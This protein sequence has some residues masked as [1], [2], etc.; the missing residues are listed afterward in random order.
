MMIKSWRVLSLLCASSCIS[1]ALTGCVLQEV[2][3]VGSECPPAIEH[4]RDYVLLGD[5]ECYIDWENSPSLDE[6]RQC[7]PQDAQCAFNLKQCKRYQKDFKALAD[8]SK[9]QKLTSIGVIVGLDGS[10]SPYDASDYGGIENACPTQF[11]TC[12]WTTAQT[13]DSSEITQFGCIQCSGSQTICGFECV[14]AKSNRNHCGQCNNVCPSNAN[15]IGGICETNGDCDDG[16]QFKNAAGSCID[17]DVNHCGLDETKQEINCPLSQGWDTGACNIETKQCEAYSCKKGFHIDK[18]TKLCVP[19]TNAC[20][21]DDCAQCSEDD[22]EVCSGGACSDR[23]IDGLAKCDDPQTGKAQCANLD[24]SLAF[25]GA[26]DTPCA[27]D[28]AKNELETSCQNGICAPVRCAQGYHLAQNNICE[29]DDAKNC[30]A[31]GY[32]CEV[33]I[34]GW[35]SG[36][37]I[38]KQCIPSSC[39]TDYHID[40]DAQTCVRDTN[41]CCGESCETCLGLNKC[42]NGQCQS[43]CSQA[44]TTCNPGTPSEY[45]ANLASDMSDCG[46]CGSVCSAA[47]VSGS[48][49]V[50]CNDGK[51]VA[52]ACN[53][54]HFLENGECTPN[55]AEH[56]GSRSVA[57]NAPNAYNTC[58][59]SGSAPKCVFECYS[60]YQKS[61]DGSRCNNVSNCGGADCT[62]IEGWASG[63][64]QNGSCVVSQ[65]LGGYILQNNSCIKCAANKQACN[66]ACIDLQTNI[67]NCGS[68]GSVCD[69]NNLSY[70]TA[71]ECQNG[72][73]VA[74]FCTSNAY[75]SDGK[76]KASSATQCGSASN[77]C[78]KIEGWKSG[79]C[80][81]NACVISQ[82]IDGY[83]LQN[84]SCIKCGANETSCNN[85]CVNTN[86]D[87][88]NCG[89]C[90]NV[91]SAS[92]FTGA[93]AVSCSSGTCKPTSCNLNYYLYGSACVESDVNNCGAKGL[94]CNLSDFRNAKTVGCISNKCWATSCTSGTLESGTCHDPGCSGAPP[95]A[96]LVNGK[97]Y[98]CPETNT[99]C[100]NASTKCLTT[101]DPYI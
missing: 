30:G 95:V 77:D 40:A 16:R 98:C 90:G 41:D 25:C 66:N 17:Y 21:G 7:Q 87:L 67:Y 59:T 84:N 47:A 80:E 69:K 26:C 74:T 8:N 61:D 79:S 71:A 97:T 24:S 27:P 89:A 52:Y 6:N 50:T 9:N 72:A 14:D 81:N 13:E 94:K 55:T 34:N 93:S 73:C 31:T 85:V 29:P 63:S 51:C 12:T 4:V 78:T 75:L 37:C 10:I 43:A 53:P 18:T 3:Q 56:C 70:A 44:Q 101:I 46:G 15:C 45:C 38:E 1:A 2:P 23:C 86:T 19:D 92:L 5:I 88:S 64:C 48:A 28:P 76:C 68:C 96:C 39:Q 100:T 35:L 58:D 99:S 33:R 11:P 65:C 60:G 36:E 22:A 91:C 20:C 82:C 62:K 32:D 83:V 42:S 49:Q 54:T 57:C